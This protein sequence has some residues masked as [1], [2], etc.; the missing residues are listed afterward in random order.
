M[1]LAGVVPAA[2]K[3]TAL[4]LNIL[5]ATVASVRFYRAG[6]F[7]WKV[8]WPFA[9]T[10]IPFAFVGGLLTL[11]DPVYKRLVG[12]VLEIAAARLLMRQFEFD[13]ASLRPVPK[14]PALGIGAG[15]G[16][17]SGL[18]GVGGGIFLSPL[19]WLTRWAEPRTIAGGSAVFILVNSISGMAGLM[20]QRP[21]WPAALPYWAV[22]VIVGGS[23]GSHLGSRR[24]GA[25]ALR[26]LLAVVL[27]IAG[28]KLLFL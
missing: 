24:L 9:V 26:Y 5:V 1:A 17:L 3:P 25:T 6:S 12:V 20:T 23:I 19:L 13:P 4:V 28:G 10:S 8:F 21:A 18:T 2:M 15:M 27:V 16:L 22:A 14:G 11:P 7:S